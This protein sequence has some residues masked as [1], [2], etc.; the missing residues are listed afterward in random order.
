MKQKII[1][2]V[3]AIFFASTVFSQNCEAYIPTKVGK[4]LTYKTSN[5]KGKTETYYSDKLLSVK[6]EDDATKYTVQRKNFDKK[7]KFNKY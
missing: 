2:S 5:K 6:N 4:K 1:L 7:E 3:I